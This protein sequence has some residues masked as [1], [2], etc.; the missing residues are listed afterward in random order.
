MFARFVIFGDGESKMSLLDIEDETTLHLM[1]NVQVS[2]WTCEIN[3]WSLLLLAGWHRKVPTQSQVSWQECGQCLGVRE[4]VHGHS[5]HWQQVCQDMEGKI[6]YHK[7]SKTI[8]TMQIEHTEGKLEKT[9]V[10]EMQILREHSD[11]LSVIAV[12]KDTVFSAS[13]DQNI[14]LHR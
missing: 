14:W 11:Y 10:T 7:A 2:N 5:Q 13:G 12:H 4:W 6:I 9:D 8:S 3:D 1:P